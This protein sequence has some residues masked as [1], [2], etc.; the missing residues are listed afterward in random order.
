[1]DVRDAIR[2]QRA[3]REYADTQVEPPTLDAI[4]QA[5]AWAPSS[6]NEQ[7]WAFILVTERATLDALS[8]AGT[9][10]DHLLTA[11]AAIALVCP[12]APDADER[13]SIALDVGQVAQSMMLTA[14]D[15]GVVSS[16]TTVHESTLVRELLGY[17]E[18]HDC[19]MVIS[20]GYPAD[21]EILTRGKSPNARRPLDE[22]VHRERW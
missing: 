2:N 19:E 7:R 9:W 13:A 8:T 22:T 11:P 21:P 10:M 1:M 18:D 14:W 20:F 6:H 4:L 3:V 15:L 17:P 16:P 12:V 5:G